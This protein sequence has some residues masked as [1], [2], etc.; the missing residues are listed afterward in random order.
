MILRWFLSRTVR[1]ATHLR[2][3][4]AR[5]VKAQQDILP[6]QGIEALNRAA[7]ELQGA[8]Q[9]GTDDATIKSRM[10][11]LEET[12]GK[13]LRP[14][15]YPSMRENVDVIL[16]ALVIALGIRTFFLQPMAIPTGSMQPTL[17]GIRVDNLQAAP[18][19]RVP[20]ILKRI[21]HFLAHGYSYY[22]IQAKTA[23]QLREVEPPRQVFPLVRT[24][25]FRVGESW[26]TIWLPPTTLPS[27]ENV[28]EEFRLFAHAGLRPDHVY[29]P[30]DDLIKVRVTSGDRLFVDRFTYNFR[31]PAR[32]EIII[33]SST[34]IPMLT[35][36]THYIKRLVAFGGE[37]VRMGNDR[38]VI[39]DGKRLDA[40][41]PRF[42]M[43]YTFEG[44][45]REDEYSGHVNNVVGQKHGRTGMA[46]LF[47]DESAVYSVLENNY[48]VLGDNTMN[49]YDSRFWGAFPR[50]KVIGRC[51]F[52]FWPIT[53]RFGWGF[54]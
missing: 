20:G 19:L 9:S 7:N 24:Q 15:P 40:S 25:R 16:V 50:E 39:V 43:I 27:Y 29:Q 49:S 34:G 14:H 30:G 31:R 41:A 18:D 37:N 32:G 28:P 2:R 35:Q 4:V 10:A 38:H 53:D 26:Y 47:P 23:G 42:E 5:M 48:F 44:P 11:T 51:G 52:V 46:P 3:R 6:P 21:G 45:P 12:A 1:E 36:H 8:V 54:R 13:W 17:Y 22:N 33:F